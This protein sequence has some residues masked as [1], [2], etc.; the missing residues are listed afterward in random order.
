MKVEGDPLGSCLLEGKHV[1]LE[2]LKKEHFEPLVLAAQGYDWPW[3]SADLS[4]SSGMTKWID[5]A[6]SLASKVEELPF[7]VYT[8]SNNQVIG[9]TRYMDIQP[10]NKVVEIG[11]TWYSKE[12][13]GTV[14][15][16][17]CKYLL[18]LHAFEDWRAIRVQLKT[19]IRNL[20]S[21]NAIMKLGAK[22]EGRLRNHRF[23]RDGSI[24]DS[25]M[26]SVTAE[27]WPGVKASLEA[28]ISS[29]TATA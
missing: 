4:S 5:H 22:F 14:V 20:H 21:Q 27:E 7:V 3:L 29:Y 9:S 13:W 10:E 2:P 17:E 16:P 28:R 18:L 1:R 15:N 6:L 11:G 23:R 12:L 25:M 19:D 26:Y 24:R 8:K